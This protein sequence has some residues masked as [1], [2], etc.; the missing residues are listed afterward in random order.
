M[1]KTHTPLPHDGLFKTFLTHPDTARDFLALYLPPELLN[2][3]RLDTLKLESGSFIEEG[4]RPYFADVLWSLKTPHGEGYIYTLIEHQSTP[5]RHMA[6]RLL[7]YSIA[8]MQ[9]HLDAGHDRLP[10]VVPILFCHGRA[11]PWP[12]TMNWL[13]LFNE[14]EMARQLYSAS[15]PL[16]DV[17]GLDDDDIMKHKRMAMLEMLLK[18]SQLRDLMA[19]IDPLVSLIE[20][21]YTTRE[22]LAA[23]TNWM[24]YTANTVEPVAFI[25]E[26]ARRLPQHREEFMTIAEALEQ[27][28]LER[29]LERGLQ[30]GQEL[31]LEQG[32]LEAMQEVAR[33]LAGR[34]LAPE[35]IAEVTGLSEQALRQLS[36]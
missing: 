3:C 5:D 20:E 4:L 15:F 25:R 14:P 6:F 1:K 17:G 16:V 30:E 8:A 26:L 27:I 36:P 9:R 24:L 13:E 10:L 31:G 28:G 34:G 22:R 11:T 18:H 35:V 7:R 29:G 19:V 32:R 23:L 33:R 2:I 12:W 21:G